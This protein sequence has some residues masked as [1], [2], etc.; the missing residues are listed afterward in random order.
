MTYNIASCDNEEYCKVLH[1]SCHF[2]L[3]EKYAITDRG[4]ADTEDG[5]GVSVMEPIGN[6]GG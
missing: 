6:E 3:V 5:E 1:S 4:N 2:V